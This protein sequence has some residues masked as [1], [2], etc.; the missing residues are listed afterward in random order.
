[1]KQLLLTLWIIFLTASVNAQDFQ[2]YS[3]KGDENNTTAPRFHVTESADGIYIDLDLQSFASRSVALNGSNTERIILT[4]GIGI[5]AKGQPDIQHLSI[6]IAIPFTGTTV[7]VIDKAEYTDFPFFNIA[8]STGDPGLYDQSSNQVSYDTA[9]YN[10]NSFYPGDIVRADDPYIW[11]DSRGQSIHFYPIQYNPVTRTLRVYDHISITLKNVNEPGLN[12]LIRFSA[13]ENSPLNAI[14]QKHYNNTLNIPANRYMAVEEQGNMLIIAHPTFMESMGPFVE[15]KNQKGISCEM[16]DV[17]TIGNGKDVAAI[18]AYVSEYYYSKGLTYLLL[19]GDDGFIPTNEATKG[20]SD[21]IYGYIS[22]DDH[23]PEVLVGRFSCETTLQCQTM[24]ERTINYEK[25]PSFHADYNN[26]LGIGSG[27]GPGDDG[28]LDF[29]HIRNIGNV[30]S[31]SVY[32]DFSELYDGSRGGNDQNGNP[33]VSMVSKAIDNGQGAIMYIGHGSV[34]SWVTTGLSTADIRRLT[35]TETHPF[36]WSAGCD[37]GGFTG[38]TCMAEE[39]LRVTSNGKPAGAVAALMSSAN[40]TW[41][42]PME[43]Q[44]EIALII[45]GKKPMN[46]STTFGGISLSGC[47]KMNDKYGQGAYVVTDNWILF[48]DP[49]VEIRNASVKIFSPVHDTLIG[50]DAHSFNISHIDSNAFVCI[51][52]NGNI[53]SSIKSAGE[54]VTLDLPELSGI[55][56][57]ILTIT[58]K[59]YLPYI[60]EVSLTS[61]PAVAINPIP[62]N[63]T[64]KGST[65]PLFSWALGGGCTPESFTFCLR[66]TGSTTWET[67]HIQSAASLSIPTLNYLTAYEWKV[68]S[69]NNK[70]NAESDIFKYSTID[71][72]DEDFE[73][74]GFPRNNWS[75]THEWY[76]DNSEAFEGNYSLHSGSTESRENSSLFY[77]CETLTCDYI[78]FYVK[79]NVLDPGANIGFYMDNFLIAEWDYTIDWTNITYAVEPGNHIFEWRFIQPADSIDGG[80]AAW[81]DNIYLPVNEPISVEATTQQT[82]PAS[83]IQLE[84]SVANYASLKW[85]T[86]GSGHFDDA[87]RMNAIYFPSETDLQLETIKLKLMV[88]ANT[89]CPVEAFDYEIKQSKLPSIPQLNDTTLYLNE[90]FTVAMAEGAESQYLLYGNDTTPA[91]LEL[92][93]TRLKAGENNITVVAAN[94]FGCS[95]TKQFF[96]NLISSSRQE[97]QTLTV[98]PNPAS[99]KINLYNSSSKG[100]TL[101][102]IYSTEGVLVEQLQLDGFNGA[103][104]QINHLNP[105]LYI[106][107]SESSGNVATGR[108]IKI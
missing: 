67:Y 91:S 108:F 19:V 83:A 62:G 107:R 11:A 66:E 90:T 76:V 25:Y 33:T 77:E 41:Y 7:P 8:P 74:E 57:L 98:Y 60:A 69:N 20:A 6:S 21:N 88:T 102:S 64:F 104:I 84:A 23:Y 97:T 101:V 92:D 30:V 78:S 14:A 80:S 38:T 24:T 68:I 55:E 40:Q 52:A 15:W 72:P 37:N 2:V 9:I 89:T 4:D 63:N 47:M 3:L 61:L 54:D 50:T 95:T 82:C 65:H 1:M 103:G 35:N 56:K 36:I 26:F 45:S 105:G 81:L 16:V 18:K 17:T 99:D 96:I 106:I 5:M 75:N 94:E 70:G 73:Q 59:N 71:A 48:G 22:G 27:L 39:F 34:N 93:A 28:E 29:E 79:M 12:E 44:D 31:E 100:T 32:P 49:S 58:G 10:R 53:I 85:V 43:A 87:T 86:T 42:P 13:N 46:V 51:S